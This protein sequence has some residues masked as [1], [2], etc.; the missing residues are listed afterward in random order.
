MRP[1]DLSA[2]SLTSKTQG[3]IVSYMLRSPISSSCRLEDRETASDFLKQR[4][5]LKNPFCS[6]I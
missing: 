3:I 5:N 1:V 2:R 4:I 6:P